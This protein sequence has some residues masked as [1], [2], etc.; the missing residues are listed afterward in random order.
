VI[1]AARPELEWS[2]LFANDQPVEIE[3]GSGKGAFLIAHARANTERNFV[4]IENQARWV[5]RIEERLARAPVANVRVVCADASLVIGRFVR[6]SS[7]AA[8]HVLFPD[9]WWKRRH[10]KRRL[11]RSDFAVHLFRT[12]EPGGVLHVATDV[13][14]RFGEMRGELAAQPFV[15]ATYDEPTPAGR[16]LSNFERKYRAVGRRLYYATFT[17]PPSR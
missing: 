3:I 4:G 13:G 16:A 17:K 12:L 5:R 10:H 15:V 8:Y 9:P 14:E 6:D 11:V 2:H 1:F 7:V